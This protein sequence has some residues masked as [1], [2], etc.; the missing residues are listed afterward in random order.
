MSRIDKYGETFV[1]FAEVDGV[2]VRKDFKKEADAK[3]W[4]KEIAP[5]PV[6]KVVKKAAPKKALFRKK[7]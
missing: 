4:L 2:E 1:A 5:A 6:K 3:A 7:R